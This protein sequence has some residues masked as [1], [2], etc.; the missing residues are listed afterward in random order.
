MRLPSFTHESAISSM[1]SFVRGWNTVSL[2]VLGMFLRVFPH[3]GRAW[4]QRGRLLVA[5]GRFGEALPCLHQAL[6]QGHQ[7][8]RIHADLAR[9]YRHSRRWTAAERSLRHA[10]EL[11]PRHAELWLELGSLYMGRQ[12]HG[13]AVHAFEQAIH[14]QPD[15]P[16]PLFHLARLHLSVEHVDAQAC[17]KLCR[18]AL[19]LDPDHEGCL[20]LLAKSLDILGRLDESTAIHTHILKKNPNDPTSLETLSALGRLPGETFGTA[21]SP[22][23]LVEPSP[24]GPHVHPQERAITYFS[25]AKVFM[26]QGHHTEAFSQFR[27]GNALVRQGIVY[28]I[29]QDALFFQRIQAVFDHDFFA[30]RRGWGHS[31]AKPVFIVGMPR[32]GTTLV[33][34]ILAAHPSCHGGGERT[35]LMECAQSLGVLSRHHQPFPEAVRELTP[36]EADLLGASFVMGLTLAGGDALRVT[37]K[38][39]H[40][41]LYLGLI[42]LLLPQARIIHCRRH[43]MDTCLSCYQQMFASLH[44]YAYDLTELGRYY[45]MHHHL[46]VHWHRTIP[47]NLLEIHYEDIVAHPKESI[48]RILEHCGL[49]WE[50]RCLEFHKVSRPVDTASLIEV[51]QPL[52]RTSVARW[53]RFEDELHPLRTALGDLLDEAGNLS[54]RP[55]P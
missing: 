39:P 31:S 14:C 36:E 55:E 4:G 35:D 12:R 26:K 1:R 44:P 42:R 18:K 53:R 3:N 45:R 38:L 27:A 47:E 10:L 9:S 43:P 50:D 29:H 48:S 7:T 40:N 5:N 17:E 22:N 25:R 21:P 20:S 2:L 41:F 6:K 52:Y 24:S 34:Q 32:S 30:V 15:H 28:D 33:E 46:M 19:T 11:E 23:T 54:K 49:P 51:R 37:E 16:T 8:A 13:A